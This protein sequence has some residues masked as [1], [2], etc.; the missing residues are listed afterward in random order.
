[1]D[2]VTLD[3]CLKGFESFRGQLCGCIPT[4]FADIYGGFKGA[5]DFVNRR[6]SGRRTFHKTK[7]LS[8]NH[9]LLFHE[10]C[11]GGFLR[12][13]VALRKTSPHVLHLLFKVQLPYHRVF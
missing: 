8:T 1:M 7:Y 5:T 3:S 10:I 13:P 9:L 6:S 4:R 12:E 11:I 2:S